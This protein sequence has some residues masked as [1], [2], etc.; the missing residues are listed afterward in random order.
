MDLTPNLIGRSWS[1]SCVWCNFAVT[2]VGIDLIGGEVGEGRDDRVM[3][4]EPGQKELQVIHSVSTMGKGKS[5]QEKLTPLFHEWAKSCW[6]L[7]EVYPA[8][9]RGI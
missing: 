9:A 1:P 8:V 6:N 7:L 4:H 3:F 5:C 2:N